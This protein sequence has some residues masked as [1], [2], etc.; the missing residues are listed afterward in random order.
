M[1]DEPET[2]PP[3][4]GPAERAKIER[5][6]NT[7]RSAKDAKS[8]LSAAAV[9]LYYARHL[10][11]QQAASASS[12]ADRIATKPANRPID[13]KRQEM[14]ILMWAQQV[15]RQQQIE[16]FARRW[17]VTPDAAAKAVDRFADLVKRGRT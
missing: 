8:A 3:I 5:A 14:L 15:P 12:S 11:P 2:A 7:L 9:L 4:I 10:H 16:A 1:S 6:L 17:S 13:P